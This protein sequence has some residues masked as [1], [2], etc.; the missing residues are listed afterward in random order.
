MWHCLQLPQAITHEVLLNLSVKPCARAFLTR[1]QK[2]N[3]QQTGNNLIHISC[4]RIVVKYLV[5]PGNIRVICYQRTYQNRMHVIRSSR[6]ACCVN[7]QRPPIFD[8]YISW[9][10][11]YISSGI[12]RS[13]PY[14]LHNTLLLPFR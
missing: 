7:L 1:Q 6:H 5:Y 11:Y 12:N 3:I 9:F 2:I 4:K 13:L 10:E 14:G 8:V